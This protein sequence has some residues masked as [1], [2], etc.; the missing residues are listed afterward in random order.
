[1]HFG[2]LEEQEVA[3]RVSTFHAG[4]VG[5][6][7]S[8]VH[9]TLMHSHKQAAVRVWLPELWLTLGGCQSPDS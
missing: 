3:K 2:W 1:M 9:G 6:V 7:H 8:L 5:G 4:C